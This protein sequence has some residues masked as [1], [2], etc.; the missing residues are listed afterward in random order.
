VPLDVEKAKPRII[1]LNN[2]DPIRMA[3]LLTK[4]FSE[5]TGGRPSFWEMYFGSDN[6]KKKIVGPLYGQLTF[7]AVPDTKK[8]IVISKIPAAYT[9]I[10][11]LIKELDSREKADIPKVI[12]LKYADAEDLCEQ[13]NAILNEPGTR[14]TLRR[15]SR[16]LSKQTVDSSG[17]TQSEAGQDDTESREDITPWWSSGGGSRQRGEEEMPIS[18]I[19]G[20]IR[21]IPVHRSKAILVLAPPEYIADI[22]KMIEELD[23]PGKQVM[24]KA[25]IVQVDHSSMTSLGIKLGSDVG[26]DALGDNAIKVLTKLSFLE[27][28]GSVKLEASMG[29]NA[30]IDFLGKQADARVLN[31]PTL[32]TKDNEE[33]EFFKGKRVPFITGSRESSEGGSRDNDYSYEPVGVTLRVRPNITPEKDVDMVINLIISQLEQETIAGQ[34]VPNELKTTTHLIVKDGET[35]MLGGILFRNTSEI[36][37]KVP[38]LGD[39]PLVGNIFRHN[40]SVESN[41]ELL[42]FITPYVIDDH[43]SMPTMEELEKADQKLKSILKEMEA[44]MSE[45]Q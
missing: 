43:S 16:G 13:L 19:I 35:V 26:L 17:Q 37:Q 41:N 44:E 18:N 39:I 27:T 31:Q 10:E 5:E 25:V 28:H 11:D 7:E 3:E 29:V 9:V 2:S 24:V 21:F 32:W 23:K 20:R 33:A 8:I 12:T 14:A 40:D 1:E 4:L 22:S 15:S 45:G 6:D 34:P 42:V 38:L 36:E 30:V